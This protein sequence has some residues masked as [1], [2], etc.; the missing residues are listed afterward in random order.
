VSSGAARHV[1][2][3]LNVIDVGSDVLVGAVVRGDFAAAARTAALTSP[4]CSRI[5]KAE[6]AVCA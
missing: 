6:N 5:Q 4:E 2:E 1:V 3:P